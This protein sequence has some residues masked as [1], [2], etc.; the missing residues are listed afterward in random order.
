[1]V[2]L[3]QEEENLKKTFLTTLFIVFLLVSYFIVFLISSRPT[4]YINYTDTSVQVDIKNLSVWLVGGNNELLDKFLD[5]LQQLGCKQIKRSETQEFSNLALTKFNDS[6]LTVF[7]GDWVSE[8]V[9]DPEFH[10]LL[11][12]LVYKRTKIA[13]IGG[14]T[15]K[16]LEALDKA[17]VDKLGRDETGNI[18]NPAYFNPPLVGFA[19]ILTY[20]LENKAYVYPSILMCNTSNVDT[21]IEELDKWWSV[22]AEQTTVPYSLREQVK[23]PDPYLQ[24]VKEYRY[25]P[26]LDSKPHGRLNVIVPIKKLMEDSVPDYDWYFYEI[27]VQTVPGYV[28]YGSDWRTADTWAKHEVHNPGTY[29][30]LVDYDPTTTS[31][32]ETVT[33]SL[34][35]S[36]GPQ[37]PSAGY[38]TS[39]SYSVSDVVVKDLSDYSEHRAYWWHDIDEKKDVGK[40]TYQSKPGFVVKTKQDHLSLVNAWYEVQWAQPPWWPWLD[41]KPLKSDVI[42]LDSGSGGGCPILWVFNGRE[43]ICEGTLNIHNPRNVDVVTSHVLST[44]LVA[45][46]GKYLFR[47]VEHEKTHSYT[48]Q[49]RLYAVLA[50]GSII[51]LSLVY[52]L[53]S[54]Y[55]NVL[56]QL[57]SSDDWRTETLGANFNNGTSQ[58]IDLKFAALSPNIDVVMFIFQIEGYNPKVK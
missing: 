30:W 39:W 22:K 17:G 38:G 47:L 11:K 1:M 53:H 32:V 4:N 41:W 27:R 50:N 23:K 8:R 14:E 43:Y 46:N 24:E 55:G 52:A 19:L 21:L 3:N 33:V 45:V 9:D 31:G 6:S 58:F 51:E 44:T 56:Q 16:L 18:R 54:E 37:G 36:A 42:Y 49:V 13:A 2:S 10:K 15:S 20:T 57:L 48:D 25:C 28:A 5:K 29:R 7:D 12:E 26:L 35:A 40:Y 34:S